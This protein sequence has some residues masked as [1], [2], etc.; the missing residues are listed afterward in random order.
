MARHPTGGAGW[1]RIRGPLPR[2]G[3][4]ADN[5]TPV[6]AVRGGARTGAPWRD[7]PRRPGRR[8]SVR[9][10]SRRRARAGAW[11]RVLAAARDPDVSTPVPDATVVRAH[12]HAAG[13]KTRPAPRPS[14]GVAGGGGR[15]PTP[16]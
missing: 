1:R 2:R 13:A 12:P 14:G 15:R 8:N 4:T 11:G 7:L 3:P 6:N 16:A 5:R 9:R 10:R